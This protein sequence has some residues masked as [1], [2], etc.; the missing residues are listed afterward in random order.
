MSVSDDEEVPE[1]FNDLNIPG[2]SRCLLT[3]DSLPIEGHDDNE[4]EVLKSFNDRNIPGHNYR[5]LV[6]DDT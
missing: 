3:D 6:D 5:L 4:Q 2:Q 1:S